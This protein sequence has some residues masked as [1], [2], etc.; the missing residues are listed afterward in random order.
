MV[1]FKFIVFVR[2]FIVSA[3]KDLQLTLFTVHNDLNINFVRPKYI[4]IINERFQIITL[5]NYVVN[6]VDNEFI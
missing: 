3:T 6:V 2:N 1:K 5:V 4:N